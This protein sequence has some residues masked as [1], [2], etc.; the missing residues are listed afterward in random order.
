MRDQ[1]TKTIS[2]L[3]SAKNW[4]NSRC[5]L[6][7]AFHLDYFVTDAQ[8]MKASGDVHVDSTDIGCSDHYLVW[9]ELGRTTKTTRKAK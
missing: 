4:C 3:G 9:M 2:L 1:R 5:A 8:L 7:S 6:F